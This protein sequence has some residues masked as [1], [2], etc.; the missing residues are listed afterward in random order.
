[1]IIT[2][3]STNARVETDG[4]TETMLAEKFTEDEESENHVANQDSDDEVDIESE[5]LEA[6]PE[7][8][9]LTGNSL[10]RTPPCTIAEIFTSGII[11][12]SDRLKS[13]LHS[14]W[15]ATANEQNLPT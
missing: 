7:F 15:M 1:M 11:S 14:F 13:K 4:E 6:L 2:G 8:P 3:C 10:D 9:A 12:L 5:L